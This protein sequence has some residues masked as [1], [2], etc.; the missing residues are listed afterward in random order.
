MN[1][2]YLI[3][4]GFDLSLGMK[5]R[6]EDF[7]EY[8]CTLGETEQNAD[9]IALK[10]TIKEGK[11]GWQDRLFVEINRDMFGGLRN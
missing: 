2:L 3:G 8:Y 1:I 4:N 6:Y 5:T 9:V 7:Y 11:E 10:K